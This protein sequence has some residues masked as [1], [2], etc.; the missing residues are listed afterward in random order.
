MSKLKVATIQ[1]ANTFAA[2]LGKVAIPVFLQEK[3]AGGPG[4]W[5]TV[6]YQFR[7]VEKDDPEVKRTALLPRADV[8][9]E[10]NQKVTADIKVKETSE[11]PSDLYAEL[12]KLD[13]LRKRGILTE[14]EFQSQKKKLLE[15]SK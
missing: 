7:V 5:P 10:S 11:K 15:G 6:E 14:E 4:Q 1:E 2:S 8:V 13:D 9:V 3:P 12:L